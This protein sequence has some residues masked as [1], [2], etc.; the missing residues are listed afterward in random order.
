MV[1]GLWFLWFMDYG[2]WF[3]VYDL[4]LTVYGLGEFGVESLGR[5]Q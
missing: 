3:K 2:L 5:I 4:R 1:Y